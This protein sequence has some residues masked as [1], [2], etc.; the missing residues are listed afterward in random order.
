MK[1][2]RI[3]LIRHGLTEGNAQ[4]RYVGHTD[5]PLSEEGVAQLQNLKD[6]IDYPCVSAVFTSPLQ[7][8]ME[9]ARLLYPSQE[10]LVIP[11]L[12]EYNFGEFEMCTAKE[13]EKNDSFARWL[14]GNVHTGIPFGESNGEFA[15]RVCSAFEKIVEGLIKTGTEQA[16]IVT[17]AGVIMT[18][19]SAY[20]LPEAPMNQWM[21]DPGYGYTIRI[22][23][24]VWMRGNKVEVI[25]TCPYRM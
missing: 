1:S 8:A 23:P 13:L 16:A 12:I 11:D 22:T 2:Y 5:V 21:M 25:D 24:A 17:H 10:P 15:H 7:R 6:E 20:G 19:L 4:G 9:S 18:L 14:Q 3:H